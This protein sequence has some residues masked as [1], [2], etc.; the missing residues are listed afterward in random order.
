MRMI[1]ADKLIEDIHKRNYI[2]KA[3]SEIFEA[4]IDEQPSA[5]SMGTKPIDNFVNP[6]EVKAGGNS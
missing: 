5:F 1:D 4:I 6:F 2:D 3:L